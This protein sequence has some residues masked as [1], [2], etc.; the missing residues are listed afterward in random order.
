[1]L[2]NKKYI[3]FSSANAVEV[4]CM[5]EIDR[6]VSEKSHMIA[7]Y[8][9][10]DGYGDEIAYMN[11]FPG[12]TF[13]ELQDLSTTNAIV[14]FMD[15]NKIPYTAIVDPHSGK[16]IEAMKG[17]PT[18]KS[19]TAAIA[20]ARAQLEKEH[21]KGV[22]RKL[23]NEIGKSETAADIALGNEKYVDALKQ[24]AAIAKKFPR[25]RGPVKG[26]LDAMRASIEKDVSKYLD[27]LESKGDVS[28]KNAALKK[29]ASA[30]GDGPLAD[31][32][33]KLVG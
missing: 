13:K 11:E 3:R 28:K 15:G 25:A 16:A 30:L 21:G 9:A 22:D 1:M 19:L 14:A 24:H 18:V 6:A 26:R 32:V 8:K 33:L 5:E 27:D 29:L 31:R 2:E 23:W 4:I 20:R 7:T 17:K 12:L 10:K